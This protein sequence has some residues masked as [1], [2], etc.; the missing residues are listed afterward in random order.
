LRSRFVERGSQAVYLSV[1]AA[2]A[3]KLRW[4]NLSPPVYRNHADYSVLSGELVVGR[5][6]EN[7]TSRQ[8]ELRMVLGDQWRARAAGRDDV[9]QGCHAR[10]G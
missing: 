9:R 5:I 1:N 3:L 7:R 2:M 8:E 4:I 6:Y 10:S